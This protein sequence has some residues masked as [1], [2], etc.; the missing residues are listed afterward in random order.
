MV[1][2]GRL[3]FKGD[4]LM[5]CPYLA[6]GYLAG[7]SFYRENI[8]C[9]KEGCEMWSTT[10]KACSLRNFFDDRKGSIDPAKE[11]TKDQLADMLDKEGGL[12]GGMID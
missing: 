3:Y 8:L 6:A 1:R 2:G 7:K 11:V 5:I 12:G 10:M 4:W 9:L